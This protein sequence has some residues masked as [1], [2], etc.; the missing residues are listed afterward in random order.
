MFTPEFKTKNTIQAKP[1]K[2]KFE[3]Q[4]VPF[5]KN[6]TFNFVQLLSKESTGFEIQTALFTGS[7]K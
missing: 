7:G 1:L 6:I 4:A 2:K 3:R 5:V